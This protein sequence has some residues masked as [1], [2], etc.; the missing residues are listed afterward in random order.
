METYFN[1]YF[2]KLQA[3]PLEKIT[4][5]SHR[6]KLEILLNKIASKQKHA[7]KILHKPKRKAGFGAPDFKV[8]CS[9]D[10][11]GYIENKKIEEKLSKTLKTDQIKK[12]LALND[13]ILLT[14]YFEFVWL[15]NGETKT[16]IL[17]SEVDIQN[18][19]AKLNAERVAAVE[20]LITKFFSQPPKQIGNAK[21]LAEALAVRAKYLKD[22]LKEELEH[23]QEESNRDKL[24]G[25]YETFKEFVFHELTIDEFADAFAQTLAY[26]L[27]L[28]KLN[29]EAKQVTLLNAKEFIPNS[30]KLI[31]ELVDFLDELKNERYSSTKWIVEEVLTIM[32]NLD[33]NEIQRSLFYRSSK[34]TD[35]FNEPNYNYSFKDPFI[36]F[37]EDF[38]AAYDKALRKAKGV[39]YTPPPIVNFI[40]RAI[41]DILQKDF[42]I[43]DGLA[44]MNK[45][46]VLDFATGTGTFLVDIIQCII[47]KTLAKTADRRLLVKEHILK[48]LYGFEYLITP[49]TIAHLKL[50]Q[51]LKDAGYPLENDERLQVYLTNTLEPASRQARIT[52][53]PA[54][55]EETKLAQKVKDKPILVI[56]GNPPYHYHSRNNG[57][58][59][60][61]KIDDYKFLDGKKLKEKN[62]K[63]LQ[64][65]Y[66]KF[67]RFAQ[68]KMDEVDEGV[69]GIVTN[70][71]FLSN[72]TFRGMRQSLMKTFNQIYFVDLHGSN[73]P[74]E[75]SPDGNNDENVFD[76]VQQGVAI[77]IFVKNKNIPK[78][79][80]HTDFWGTENNKIKM[81][82]NE[83][84]ESIVWNEVNAKTP[85][86]LFNNFKL[87]FEETYN[88]GIGMTEI[89]QKGSVGVVSSDDENL[90]GFDEKSLFEKV[91]KKYSPA[92]RNKILPINISPFDSRFIY[93][94]SKILERAREKMMSNFQFGNFALVTSKQTKNNFKHVFITDAIT[95]YN[96]LDRAGSF[97][98]G[99]IYPLYYFK[100]NEKH[101]N[102]QMT[103]VSHINKLYKHHFTPEQIFSYIFS[104]LH[105]PTYRTKYA[106]FLKIDFPRIP[107]IED[108][109]LFE[110]LSDAGWQLIQVHLMRKEALD[111]IKEDI[112]CSDNGNYEVEK[113][114]FNNDKL[115][116]NNKEYFY[117][118]SKQVYDFYIGGYQ[119]LDKYLKDRKGRKLGLLEVKHI[120]NI[121]KVIGFTIQQMEKINDLTKSWI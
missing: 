100:E 32:N 51:Y 12:Y 109:N 20:A 121:I 5:H 56:V 102:F 14:N 92:E 19:K 101:L 7:L 76:Q 46:T 6:G 36:Y 116:I 82:L 38:L 34:T 120:S 37:Y 47:E 80:F 95:N 98:A 106:E 17:C 61:N 13:N 93:Y 60:K 72:L 43:K 45:V 2:K 75:Y 10:I 22:F 114:V 16:E 84:L 63:G 68:D 26:G 55:S 35:L 78:K 119:V 57:E 15:K 103:F 94:D 42:N 21:K 113:P 90:K 111:N 64:D 79:I 29:A 85:F 99:F 110:Q 69:A 44:D 3:T 24:F 97:G 31:R 4:E 83:G 65:D 33:L 73:K 8:T 88:K 112:Q 105:S 62:P 77:S 40:V 115:F 54:L 30:F 96:Y 18:R 58:W 23:Q 39:Y 91:N 27:F 1:D 66:V 81:C 74:K 28:A 87:D 70:H 53:L 108:K 48:N 107:F 50:S 25:L 59:I 104:I 71:R 9:G 117:P 11:V 118:V 86:Y 49:Y 89:F 52:L 67:I 41:D